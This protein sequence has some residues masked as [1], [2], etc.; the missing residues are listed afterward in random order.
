MCILM[1]LYACM[2]C[3]VWYVCSCRCCV[4]YH[5]DNCLG[6]LINNKKLFGVLM[7]FFIM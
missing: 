5:N 3:Q 7:I 1:W 6:V 4:C 2:D